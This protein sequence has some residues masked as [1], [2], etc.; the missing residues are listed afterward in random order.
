[1]LRRQSPQWV[2]GFALAA[3]GSLVLGCAT[4][5]S[6]DGVARGIEDR[7]RVPVD[8]AR[9]P[10]D[11]GAIPSGVQIDDGVSADEAVAIALWNSPTL[12]VDLARLTAADADLSQAR[13][14][15]NPTLR[16]LFPSGP[17]QLSVLLTWPL[18]TL[19]TMPRRIRVARTTRQSTIWSIVQ[20]GLDLSRDV[21]LA[22]VD[23]S[24]ACDRAVVRDAIASQWREIAG[25][26]AARAAA[27]DV[28]LRDARGAEA[29]ARVADDEAARARDDIT[30]ARARMTV[31]LGWGQGRA[32]LRPQVDHVLSNRAVDLDGLTSIA[33]EQRP[34]LRAAALA[35]EAAGARVGLERAA[36]FTLAGVGTSLTGGVQAEL[37]IASQNQGGIGRAR[38]QLEAA[39]WRYRELRERIAGEVAQA[40]AQLARAERS[41]VAYREMIVDAR[42]RDLVAATAQYELGDSDYGEVLLSAQRLELARLREVE[43]AA[44]ERRAAAELER[45]I[46]GRRAALPKTTARGIEAPR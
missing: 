1:V 16:F 10:S 18:E 19:V 8:F 36:V 45:A 6:T 2:R 41:T 15:S 12:R 38:A 28:A 44:D 5:H 25:M 33:I 11:P 7:V 20:S 39:T 13:R 3:G 17:Q 34:D 42:N 30:V 24:L 27:G 22:H 9:T 37:P 4:T 35:I 40:H 32:E 14:P 26:T 21:R 43:I 23:W 46:G 31:L 29:D